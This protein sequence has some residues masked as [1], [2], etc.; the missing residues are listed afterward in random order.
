MRAK[1]R[2]RSFNE[3]RVTASLVET[4]WTKGFGSCSIDELAAAA[5]VSKP[6]LYAAFGDKKAMYIVALKRFSTELS[7]ALQG[8]L[9]PKK[10]LEEC[11]LSF[12][13]A[14]LELFLRGDAG[15]RGCL[16]M[17]TAVTEAV[18]EPVIRE[19]LATVVDV[20]DAQLARRFEAARS[21]GEISPDAE[22]E[23]LAYLAAAAL[24]SLAIRTRAGEP[25]EQLERIAKAAV[26]SLASA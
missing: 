8:T 9:D 23:A 20:I 26:K 12:F 10:P 15:P 6:S 3:A 14:N 13:S 25:R 5:G 2:P 19:A 16:V 18:E 17:C 4:F 7:M 22:P 24:H 1:G 21:K 11:L